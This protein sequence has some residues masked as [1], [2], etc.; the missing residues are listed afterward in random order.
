MA[1]VEFQ[2][3]GITS[4]I[5]CDEEQKMSEI[6]NNFIS[7]S[8]LNENNINYIYDD[9]DGK[10]F[11]KNLTFNEMANYN[12]KIRK[13]MNILVINNEN[14]INN[15][16]I[17]LTIKIEINDINK[18][19]YFLDNVDGVITVGVKLNE[20]SIFGLDKIEEEHHHDFLKELNDSNTELYINDKKC[21]YEKYFIPE[22]KGEYNIL[23]KF[24]I[25]MTD[26]SFMFYN[27]N[28]LTNI[29]LSSFNT[30]NVTNMSFM[31]CECSNLTNINLSSFN[32]QNVTNMFSIFSNCSK[33]TNIYLSSFNIKN[34]INMA[35]M[36]V[37]CNELINLN[38]SS[39]YTQN[40]TNMV[41]MFMLCSKLTNINL[42]SFNTQNVTN[43]FGMFSMCSN[44]KNIDLSS[45]NTD[46]VINMS[47]MFGSCSNLTNIDLSSF[48]TQN[49]TD[50][51][52]M[53]SGCSNLTNIN[54]SSFN[55]QNVNDMFNIFDMCPCLKEIKINKKFLKN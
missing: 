20:N 45:F 43:M 34:V 37:G 5:E 24:N 41:N 25:L 29:D 6:C 52:N 46:K 13:K 3:D 26:C 14:K 53:F 28:N 55:T 36:F 31:F 39:F 15:N 40:V 16:Q 30:Q 33:L 27:C 51:S 18:K 35:G 10:Q 9:K 32:T 19:I 2:Y 54:L 50:M 7:K 23:L 47:N 48:N 49:V 44:L 17:K 11:D 38:L 1:Q 8:N 12:D 21:K 42:S 4:I 22:Q